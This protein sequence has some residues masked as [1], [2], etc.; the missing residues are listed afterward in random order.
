[1]HRSAIQFSVITSSSN[2]FTVSV[3]ERFLHIYMTMTVD[4]YILNGSNSY[5]KSLTK[6]VENVQ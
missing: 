4:F 1:M 2:K 5:T 3:N 6:F